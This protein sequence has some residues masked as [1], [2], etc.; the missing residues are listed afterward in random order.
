[1]S[2]GVPVGYFGRRTPTGCLVWK[3][4]TAGVVPLDARHDVRNHS[5]DGFEWG[6]GGSGPA[7]LALAITLDAL[8]GDVERARVL[9]QEFKWRVIARLPGDGWQLTTPF[10]V[11]ALAEIERALQPDQVR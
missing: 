2:A 6:Y 8:G 5:P 3:S 10:V 1:M 9:Y 7:Q 11:G 4:T